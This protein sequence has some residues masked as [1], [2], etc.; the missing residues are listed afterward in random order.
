[1]FTFCLLTSTSTST[2]QV[3]RQSEAQLRLS[4]VSLR[5][6]LAATGAT[7]AVPPPAAAGPPAS[8]PPET[9]ALRQQLA[10]LQQEAAALRQRLAN[11][12]QEAATLRQ[13]LAEAQVRSGGCASTTAPSQAWFYDMRWPRR[14]HLI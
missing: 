5:Q 8:E 1:M 6:Q 11:A 3:L 2:P 4:E 7:H 13:Q 12:Q 9:A 10:E 14:R